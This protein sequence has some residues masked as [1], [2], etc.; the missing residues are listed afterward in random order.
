MGALQK[1]AQVRGPKQTTVSHVVAACREAGIELRK[2]DG[3]GLTP[4]E[5]R[6]YVFNRNLCLKYGEAWVSREKIC[7]ELGLD[8]K[9]VTSAFARFRERAMILTERVI[10]AGEMLPNGERALTLCYARRWPLTAEDLAP[11]AERWI[12]ATKEDVKAILAEE[13]AKNSDH[14]S[15]G[16]FPV[17]GGK[18]PPDLNMIL[19]LRDL[20]TLQTESAGGGEPPHTAAGA[21]AGGVDGSVVAIAPSVARVADGA[22]GGGEDESALVGADGADRAGHVAPS[23][24]R[25][26]KP[27][28]EVR[29]PEESLGGDER[30]NAILILRYCRDRLNPTAERFRFTIDIE[31]VLARRREGASMALLCDAVDGALRAPPSAYDATCCAPRHVFSSRDRVLLLAS[32]L[33]NASAPGRRRAFQAFSGGAGGGGSQTVSTAVDAGEIGATLPSICR[34]KLDSAPESVIR[35]VGKPTDQQ[36]EDLFRELESSF[37]MSVRSG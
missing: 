2:K 33:P 27:T 14:T 28:S 10:R 1:L 34:K 31:T 21:P 3:L 17:W 6:I 29:R 12:E 36:I 16:I 5:V 4:S 9:T 35:P 19:N 13:F 23:H 30:Q 26:L 24:I 20:D 7:A 37:R 22:A 15:G 11:L 8:P 18:I 25:E 32:Y